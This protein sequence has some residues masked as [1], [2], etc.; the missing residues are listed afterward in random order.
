AGKLLQ[1]QAKVA[2]PV[3][4]QRTSQPLASLC[5]QPEFIWIKNARI[6]EPPLNNVLRVQGTNLNAL[7]R[8]DGG[9][10]ATADDSVGSAIRQRDLAVEHCDLGASRALVHRH[11]ELRSLGHAAHLARA[12]RDAARASSAGDIDR[13]VVQL[14]FGSVRVAGSP[15][16]FQTGLRLHSEVGP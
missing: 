9:L 7:S 8:N 10:F 13:S 2:L 14:Q 12:N 11:E 1:S 4:G 5:R 6:I 16:D 3:S 15:V